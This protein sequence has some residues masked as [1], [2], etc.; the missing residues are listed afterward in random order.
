[1]ASSL[2]NLVNDLAEG[3]YR[4]K[5][6]YRHDNKKCKTSEIKYTNCECLLEQTNFQDNLIKYKRLCFIN[7]C[8]CCKKVFNLLNIL[9]IGKKPMELHHLKKKIFT[10][11]LTWKILLMQITHTEKEFV[12]ILKQKL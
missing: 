4:I 12:K 9:M 8:H 6:K 7:L 2:S 10:V 1:M 5:C 3:I 11:N